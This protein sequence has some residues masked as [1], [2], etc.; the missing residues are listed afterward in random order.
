MRRFARVA[1]VL[2]LLLLMAGALTGYM[3]IAVRFEER[4]L[5]SHFGARYAEYRR[6][7]PMFWPRVGAARP[8]ADVAAQGSQSNKYAAPSKSDTWRAS[9]PSV[10][11]TNN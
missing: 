3:L 10:G 5:L 7:V 2:V 4:D 11:T 8:A 9:P 1:V 6:R